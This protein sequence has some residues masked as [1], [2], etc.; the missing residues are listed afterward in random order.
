MH[1]HLHPWALDDDVLD[2]DRMM[3]R[4]TSDCFLTYDGMIVIH[5][6][7]RFLSDCRRPTGNR[8]SSLRIQ[9]LSKL[10]GGDTIDHDTIHSTIHTTKTLIPV[11]PTYGLISFVA[12]K[13]TYEPLHFRP[14]RKQARE[15]K[16]RSDRGDPA[17]IAQ[18]E[19]CRR[20][21]PAIRLPL[22]VSYLDNETTDRPYGGRALGRFRDLRARQLHRH[23]RQP[24]KRRINM[25]P[26][27]R[28]LRK[29]QN[30]ARCSRHSPSSLQNSPT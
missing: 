7:V 13:D 24:A 1:M 6:D 3:T 18:L 28:P 5:S 19:T 29:S 20:P 9:K 10:G 23:R 11:Y 21:P 22:L 4:R 27:H 25:N 30:R 16:R 2:G 12:S 26:R 14:V 15:K 17:R 8:S